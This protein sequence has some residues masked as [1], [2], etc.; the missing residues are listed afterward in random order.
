MGGLRALSRP[1][2]AIKKSCHT[3]GADHSAVPTLP[4]SN[5]SMR[6]LAIVLGLGVRSDRDRL[7]ARACGLAAE[8]LSRVRSGLAA[9]ARQAWSCRGGRRRRAFRRRVVRRAIPRVRERR[10]PWANVTPP[11]TG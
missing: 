9:R 6:T 2:L 5:S 3:L 10:V 8:R 11:S 7:L 4:R 1:A